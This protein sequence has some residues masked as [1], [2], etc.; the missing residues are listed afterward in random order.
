MGYDEIYRGRF[1]GADHGHP[2]TQADVDALRASMANID[3]AKRIHALV[4][5]VKHNPDRA[6]QVAAEAVR[7][8]RAWAISSRGAG[9]SAGHDDGWNAGYD[10]GWEVLTE[11]E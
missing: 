1:P 10:A 6:E 9:Y 2:R 5:S 7:V 11:R 8:A 4:E 3:Y